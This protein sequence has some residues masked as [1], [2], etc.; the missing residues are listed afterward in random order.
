MYSTNLNNC[1]SSQLDRSLEVLVPSY[2]TF[3]ESFVCGD[4]IKQY[5]TSTYVNRLI[6]D[7]VTNSMKSKI[8]FHKIKYFLLSTI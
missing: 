6:P 8:C 1:D 4:G 2:A 3:E 7:M 5:Y